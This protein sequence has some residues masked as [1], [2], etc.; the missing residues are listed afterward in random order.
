MSEPPCR[1]PDS[2]TGASAEI[3]ALQLVKRGG[4]GGTEGEERE[5]DG[6]VDGWMERREGVEGEGGRGKEKGKARV[7]IIILAELTSPHSTSAIY[8]SLLSCSHASLLCLPPS[9]TPTHP[10]PPPPSPSLLHPHKHP[11]QFLSKPLQ[12][13]Q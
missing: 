6:W 2:L 12:E 13:E 9:S 5:R 7:E 8:S 10:P 3:S 4:D 11:N 1:S